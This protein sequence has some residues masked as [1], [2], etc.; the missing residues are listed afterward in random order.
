MYAWQ[1]QQILSAVCR[2]HQVG[3]D[4]SITISENKLVLSTPFKT[5]RVDLSREG[6]FS[7]NDITDVEEKKIIIPRR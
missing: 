4:D 3:K 2:E 5:I 6:S 1:Y 7:I